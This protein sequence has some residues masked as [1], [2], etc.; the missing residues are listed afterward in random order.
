MGGS[1]PDEC[2]DR[3]AELPPVPAENAECFSYLYVIETALREL[4]VECLEQAAGSRWYKTR[5]PE[6]PL[7]SFKMGRRVER[8]CPWHQSVPL[9]PIYYTEFPHLKEIIERSDNWKDTFDLATCSTGL[10]G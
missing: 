3:A 5:L 9:H 1:T 10:D 4:I 6:N 7:E 2:A 8:E